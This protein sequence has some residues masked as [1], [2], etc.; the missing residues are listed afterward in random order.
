LAENTQSA[1]VG[2]RRQFAASLGAR[3]PWEI[4]ISP[5]PYIRAGSFRPLY[6]F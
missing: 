1:K 2:N 4:H 3:R 6:V 5:L